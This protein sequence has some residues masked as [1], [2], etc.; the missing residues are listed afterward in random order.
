MLFCRNYRN[1]FKMNGY[2]L[3]GNSF[4]IFI[5][6]SLHIWTSSLSPPFKTELFSLLL[7]FR[8]GVNTYRK[9]FVPEVAPTLEGFCC[10][11]E[12]TGNQKNCSS[13]KNGRKIWR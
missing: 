13:L 1:D 4:S 11:C 9:E 8:T 7:P 5:I 2:T 6:T 10:P 3:L 12:Q